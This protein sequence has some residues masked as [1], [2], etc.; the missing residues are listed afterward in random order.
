MNNRKKLDSAKVGAIIA[1]AGG[2]Q[3][4]GGVDKVFALLGGKSALAWVVDVFQQ[5]LSVHQIVVVVSQRNIELARRLAIE[6]E[7]SKVTEVCA[8]GRRRQDSVA[9]GLS[10]LDQCHW[11]VIHDGAARY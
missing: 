2:S 6:R 11:A 7:W 10:R 1:A 9:A 3:R 8:G 4:M 5:C